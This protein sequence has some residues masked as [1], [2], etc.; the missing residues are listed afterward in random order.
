MGCG[1][2]KGKDAKYA[3]DEEEVSSDSGGSIASQCSEASSRTGVTT[4]SS[5]RGKVASSSSAMPKL[6]QKGGRGFKDIYDFGGGTA[7]A[8]SEQEK[9]TASDFIFGDFTVD[10]ND[11]KR[12][13]IERMNRIRRPS[14]HHSAD[15]GEGED[16]K[17]LARRKSANNVF[18]LND[19]VVQTLDDEPELETLYTFYHEIP[20]PKG[21]TKL[22]SVSTKTY[23][24]HAERI[25]AVALSGDE[26]SYLSAS[27]TDTVV[28][29]S[30]VSTGEE[31]NAYPGQ[32]AA[33]V[34]MTTST[35]G[36]YFA[37]GA[38]DGSIAIWEFCQ[39]RE[40]TMKKK[41]QFIDCVET[42]G[43]IAVALAFSFNDKYLAGAFEDGICRVFEV[44]T[45]DLFIT[46]EGHSAVVMAIAGHP[47]QHIMASGGG[48]KDV[49][50]WETKS[51]IELRRLVGHTAPIISVNFTRDGERILS[52]DSQS[53]RVW[54][55]AAS[56]CDLDV[57]IEKIVGDAAK[58]APKEAAP[59]PPANRRLKFGVDREWSRRYP[60]FAERVEQALAGVNSAAAAVQRTNNVFRRAVFTISVMCPGVLCN[61]YFAVASTNGFIYIVDIVTGREKIKLQ[62][63]APV[64]VLSTGPIESLLYGDINGNIYRSVLEP[65]DTSLVPPK[66]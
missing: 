8:E 5:T 53:C 57:S 60:T 9:E 55:H 64:F 30:H 40:H 42:D 33:V 61:S 3:D 12:Q 46:F 65:L 39:T 17:G 27:I 66:R 15:M 24:G 23:A 4:V 22:R 45:A 6:N 19:F 2:S 59:A 7:D 10:P 43:F 29:V 48:D 52:N 41:V 26:H 35:D 13:K 34:S 25:K 44:D 58:P 38:R 54:T 21:F 32:N 14:R 37:V 36:K 47:T 50:L 1:A 16:G 56:K 51:G 31:L 49:V 28:S 63:K 11:A 18:V 20:V 62:T